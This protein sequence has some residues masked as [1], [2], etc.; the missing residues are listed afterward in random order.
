[1]S[2][3]INLLPWRQIRRNNEKK[4]SIIVMVVV[5]MIVIASGL[6]VAD[7]MRRFSDLQV[8]RNQRIGYEIERINKH[9]QDIEKLKTQK[10]KLIER[11][12]FMQK[13]NNDASLLLHLFSELTQLIPEE[14]YLN[15]FRQDDAKITLQGVA[16]SNDA[17]SLL[18]QNV[19]RNPWLQDAKLVEIKRARYTGNKMFIL[20][21]FLSAAIL[22]EPRPLGSG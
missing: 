13:I 9:I 15:R 10:K 1:M 20:S 8:S 3:D 16:A 12:F 21:F 14:I 18:I 19:E 2:I 11:L 17:I 4:T 6:L 5:L 7:Y 22:P